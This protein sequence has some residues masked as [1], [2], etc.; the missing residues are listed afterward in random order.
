MIEERKET[1]I[2]YI[3][4]LGLVKPLTVWERILKMHKTLG[5]RFIF[6]DLNYSLIFIFITFAGA[7]FLLRQASM[8]FQYSAAVMFSPV[9]FLGIMLF[10]EIN[11]RACGLFELKQTCHYMVGHITALR[12][13]YYSTVS[14]LFAVFV[15]AFSTVNATQ[16]FRMLPIC[17][18]VLFICAAIELSIIRI[19]RSKFAVVVFP[20]L[21]IVANLACQ[22]VF[23]E[24]WEL[25]LSGAPLV[26]TIA[27]AIAG[28]LIFIFQMKKMLMEENHYVNA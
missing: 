14:T 6:W 3:L 23:R 11:E 7:G 25:F 13:L 18:G 5:L 17:L 15:I 9:L 4:E 2:E 16:F 12:C 27:F 20:I 22:L 10:A 1:S 28:A 24:N 21:W 26:A 19:S 8:E